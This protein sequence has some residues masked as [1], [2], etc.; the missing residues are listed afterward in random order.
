MNA[1]H[2]GPQM[3][4]FSHMNATET[5]DYKIGYRDEWIDASLKGWTLDPNCVH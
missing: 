3:G 2:H 4:G 5:H 1:F